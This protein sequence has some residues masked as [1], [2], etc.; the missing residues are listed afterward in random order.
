VP[1]RRRRE[2]VWRTW[3][4]LEN[5][6]RFRRGAIATSGS[7][8]KTPIDS[9]A[10]DHLR[11]ESPGGGYGERQARVPPRRRREMVF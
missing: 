11:V 10:G 8:G 2:I 3:S 4:S 7:P 1:L 6:S 5:H 9:Q